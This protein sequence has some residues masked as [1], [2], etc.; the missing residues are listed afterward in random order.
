MSK[1]SNLNKSLYLFYM[2]NIQIIWEG[3]LF[4]AQKIQFLCVFGIHGKELITENLKPSEDFL[5]LTFED[6]NH[7]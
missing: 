5:R 1:R 6:K 7:N 4:Q 2:L 3:Q